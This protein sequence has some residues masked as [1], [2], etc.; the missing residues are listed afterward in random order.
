[1]FKVLILL[2]IGI[3][4]GYMLRHMP[5]LHK[6]E[7][8]TSLTIFFMLFVFGLT[9]GSNDEL[10]SSLGRFGYQAFVLAVAGICGS[11]LASY[12]AYR[13]IFKKGGRDEK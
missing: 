7:K 10:V 6:V 8:T 4:V 5:M 9:I 12:L 3:G 11:L 1:M 2:F 13:F